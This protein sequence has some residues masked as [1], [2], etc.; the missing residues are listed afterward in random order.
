MSISSVSVISKTIKDAL[1][2]FWFLWYFNT[3]KLNI[4]H[5]Q[6]VHTHVNLNVYVDIL[7]FSK[8]VYELHLQILRC[9]DTTWSSNT[10]CKATYNW[11]T[12]Q[13]CAEVHTTKTAVFINIHDNDTLEYWLGKWKTCFWYP[14]THIYINIYIYIDIYIDR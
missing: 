6:N 5:Y 9:F 11:A 7:A 10:I 8:I 13:M 14:H 12:N 3:Q 1:V 4:D 2:M